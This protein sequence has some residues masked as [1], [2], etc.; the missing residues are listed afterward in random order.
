MA[1]IEL[2][3]IHKFFTMGDEKIHALNDI[4]VNIE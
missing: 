4:N 1:L 2:K 3:N